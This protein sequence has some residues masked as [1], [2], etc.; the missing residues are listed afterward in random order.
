MKNIKSLYIILAGILWGSMGIFV[1][2]LNN[3]GF[4]SMEMVEIRS[5][6]TF[7]TLFVFLLIYKKELFKIKIKDIWCFIGTGIISITFFSFCY[8]TTIQITSMA[9]AAILLYTSPIFVMLF[10]A[11]LF[12][13]TITKKKIIALILAFL[14]C[15]FVGGVFSTSLNISVF[16]LVTGIFSGIGYALYSIFSRYAIN[17][18]YETFTI[19]F[20]TFFFAC[21]GGAFFTD[22]NNIAIC[23]KENDIKFLFFLIVFAVITTVLP[24]LLYTLGLKYTENSKASIIV[25]IEPVMATIFGFFVFNEKPTASV[26]V[27]IILVII[28]IIFL[29]VKIPILDLSSKNKEE[30]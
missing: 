7:L 18:K 17:K 27:G 23:I 24:Y 14:G 21:I 3:F 29:N 5:V 1:R 9:V 8:F 30:N 13:E 11:I 16:G 10:S 28:A 19:T 2:R 25:S 15:A 6:I 26:L 22:F 12:K 20:Y 4:T